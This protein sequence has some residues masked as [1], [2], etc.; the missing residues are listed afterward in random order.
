M[1]R[2]PKEWEAYQ[3]KKGL[4]YRIYFWKFDA[5]KKDNKVLLKTK[6]TLK[7]FEDKYII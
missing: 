6:I 2:T 7:D 4:F 1:K 5:R 3:R